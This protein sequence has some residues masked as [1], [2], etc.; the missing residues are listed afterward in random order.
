MSVSWRD[1]HASARQAAGEAA[2]EGFPAEL[3]AREVRLRAHAEPNRPS[4]AVDRLA[5][6][7][8][9][10]LPQVAPPEAL[11][12]VEA[13]LLAAETTGDLDT[14]L[15]LAEAAEEADQAA[16]RALAPAARAQRFYQRAL[17]FWEL[18][19][20]LSAVADATSALEATPDDVPMLSNRGGWL[21]N[22]GSPWAAVGDWERAV[23]VQPEY[24]NGWM[25]IATVLAEFG[26]RDRARFCLRKALE[27]ALEKWPYRER[28]E[29]QLKEWEQE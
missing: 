18:G 6:L 21:Y 26:Q 10:R 16:G 24:A 22:L 25:K 7:L 4:A 13:A 29:A 27:V 11:A 2:R 12:A 15:A 9:G 28:V 19:D 3:V 5:W 23:K 1:L 20:L 14:V 8:T 17:H